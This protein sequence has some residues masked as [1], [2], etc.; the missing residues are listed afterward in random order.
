M[1]T[2]H[3]DV[4]LAYVVLDLRHVV[5]DERL[6]EAHARCTAPDGSHW[7]RRAMLIPVPWLFDSGQETRNCRG[8]I[9][10]RA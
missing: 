9:G 6:G 1:R 10:N 8:S 3:A 4:D 7:T 5:A 2:C